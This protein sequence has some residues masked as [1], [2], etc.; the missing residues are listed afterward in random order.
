MSPHT[1]TLDE[2]Y[3]RYADL[4]LRHHRLLSEDKDEDA[5]TETVEEEMTRL[6]DR[7]DAM[8]RRSLLG[9]GSGTPRATPVC[10]TAAAKT[11]G[12]PRTDHRHNV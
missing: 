10:L 1:P 2:M 4:L 12:G 6:W 8:Q 5:E 9:L 11:K 3:R 7:L